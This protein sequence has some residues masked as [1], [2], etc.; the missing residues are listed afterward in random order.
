MKINKQ[1]VLKT[2]ALKRFE[3]NRKL[4]II[5]DEN[6]KVYVQDADSSPSLQYLAQATGVNLN[7]IPDVPP[8]ESVWILEDD[9][10]NRKTRTLVD[11]LSRYDAVKRRHKQIQ[12]I[13]TKLPKDL[14]NA[15][16]QVEKATEDIQTGAISLSPSEA[17][18]LSAYF[19][20]DS[21]EDQKIQNY[22]KRALISE[23]KRD[24]ISKNQPKGQKSVNEPVI[25]KKKTAPKRV[26]DPEKKR[27]AKEKRKK[28]RETE[29][30]VKQK[31]Y[32]EIVNVELK[33]AQTNLEKIA[34]YEELIPLVNDKKDDGRRLPGGRRRK[35]FEE[36]AI[37]YG[38]LHTL[39]FAEYMFQK[40]DEAKD[41]REQFLTARDAAINHSKD[42][43]AHSDFPYMKKDTYYR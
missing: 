7:K 21:L 15:I 38:K 29:R 40:A 2:Y 23:I 6:Q 37:I 16:L 20:S 11:D 8:V 19:D 14:G 13:L 36:K 24:Y 34:L 5:V 18:F 10:F 27:I 22:I 43:S 26:D 4:P 35:I 31:R 39:Y 28:K 25:Q 12:F 32:D 17:E 41:K 33:N 3:E 42:S 1:E 9:D 30:L